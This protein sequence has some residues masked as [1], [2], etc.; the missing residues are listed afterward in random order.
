M[1]YRHLRGFHR[2]VTAVKST[3]CP[4]W[5]TLVLLNHHQAWFYLFSFFWLIILWQLH[6]YSW[7]TLKNLYPLY[8]SLPVRLALLAIGFLE[9]QISAVASLHPEQITSVLQGHIATTM[10]TLHSHQP[11]CEQSACPCRDNWIRPPR[12]E[13]LLL[14]HTNRPRSDLWGWS[15]VF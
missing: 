9:H 1:Q 2:K 10:L 12:T 8:F 4:P 6:V 14:L 5:T 3:F 15:W 11:K 7:E 13:L